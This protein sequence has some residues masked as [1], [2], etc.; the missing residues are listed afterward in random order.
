MGTTR[1]N[2]AGGI[3]FL[4]IATFIIFVVF[5]SFAHAAKP[6]GK[7]KSTESS[8]STTTSELTATDPP[9]LYRASFEYGYQAG[10]PDATFT[11]H[12][13]H[14]L[15][16]ATIP[17]ATTVS[18]GGNNVV[19][20]DTASV[21]ATD[22]VTFEGSVIIRLNEILNALTTGDV[23]EPGN[24]YD[25]TVTTA[26]GS[27]TLSAYFPRR[28][29]RSYGSCPCTYL[30]YPVSQL[31]TDQSEIVGTTKCSVAEGIPSEEY[32]EAGYGYLDETDPL[33]PVAVTRIAGS[34]TTGTRETAFASICFVRDSTDVLTTTDDVYV[35]GPLPVSD[36]DHYFC[37]DTIVN[38]LESSACSGSP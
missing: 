11:L 19:F 37:A 27:A 15:V 4:L 3:T 22:F 38:V 31:L 32:V 28:I 2:T 30:N 33:N 25:V 7:G 6:A 23:L 5:V 35:E 18:I 10:Y 20:D 14:L 1:S 9:E 13:N 16:D 12:G 26:N 17:S 24:T 8:T 29:V 36:Y 21:G 34:H